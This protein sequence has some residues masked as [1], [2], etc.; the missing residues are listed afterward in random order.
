[1]QIQSINSYNLKNNTNFKSAI[2]VI[3]WEKVGKEFK[4]VDDFNTVKR[5]QDI[6]VRRA[7][8]TGSSCSEAIAD[9]QKVMGLLDKKDSDYH[10]MFEKYGIKA[11]WKLAKD[12]IKVGSFYPKSEETGWK[13]GKFNPFVYLTTGMDSIA[14][15]DKGKKIGLTIKQ[16]S[17]SEKIDRAKENYVQ[18]GKD[19]YQ[20]SNQDELHVILEKDSKLTYK[21]LK[22]DMYPKEGPKNPL[23]IMGYYKAEK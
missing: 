6:L 17:S 8:G 13:Y 10:I 7:N 21:I 19:L 16:N 2:P 5:M 23:A 12:A 15:R 1:M 14:L 4:L 11:L 22:L 9:R 20:R 18:V 3:Y